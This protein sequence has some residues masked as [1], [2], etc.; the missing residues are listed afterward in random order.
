MS[1]TPLVEMLHVGKRFGGV[2]AVEDVSIDLRRGEVVG[3]LG[4][5]GA[6][7]TTLMKTLSGAQ[8]LDTGEIRI[9]GARVALRTP[10]DARAHGIETLYQT[11]ALADNLDAP[12]NMFLGRERLTAYG[13]LDD[14]A[15]ESATRAVMRRLNPSFS[16]FREPVKNLSGGE[17]QSVAIARAIQFDA[18]ILILDEPTAA[19]GPQETQM[20][21]DLIRRSKADGLGIFLVSHDL[22]DVFDLADR[23]AVLKNG[24]LVGT[25]GTADVS[26]DDVLAMIIAG[27]T[28]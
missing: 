12:A 7:K 9:A 11:L 3:V 8:P 20:V 1:P 6:G 17:R 16:R 22:H 21:H 14:D 26:K 15:M 13:T 18:R 23:V 25:C 19:L 28:G 4:H 24:R 5:N 27:E 2:R 10:R